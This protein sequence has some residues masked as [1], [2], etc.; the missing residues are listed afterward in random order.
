M[1]HMG[2]HML[3]VVLSGRLM[4]SAE[5]IAGVILGGPEGS[6]I[7]SSLWSNITI[8]MGRILMKERVQTVRLFQTKG[9]VFLSPDTRLRCLR[10]AKFLANNLRGQEIT[11]KIL[12]GLKI[13]WKIIRGAK[14]PVPEGRRGMTFSSAREIF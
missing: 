6:G 12:R 2:P 3:N 13:T 4:R 10:G 9:P 5:E 8:V 14:F 1:S 7:F 11:R